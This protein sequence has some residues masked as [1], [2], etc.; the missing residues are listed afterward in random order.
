MSRDGYYGDF[1]SFSEEQRAHEEYMSHQEQE[2]DVVPYKCGNPMWE[3]EEFCD[4]CKAKKAL[5]GK[6]EHEDN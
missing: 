1:G 5:S 4:S 3:T 2:P 6:E